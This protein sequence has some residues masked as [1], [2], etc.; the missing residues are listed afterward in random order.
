MAGWTDK[1]KE[2]WKVKNTFQVILILIVFAC[3]GTTVALIAKP[4]LRALFQREDTP[5]WATVLYYVL[6]L[7]IYNIF[8]LL[9]GLLFGQ[10]SFFWNFEKRFFAR[11]FGRKQQP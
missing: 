11:L 10:F 9:F 6:I 4:L 5:T 1:L 3:T 8:L 7:P 2:R